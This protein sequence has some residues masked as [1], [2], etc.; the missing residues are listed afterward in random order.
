MKHP[1]QRSPRLAPFALVAILVLWLAGCGK[2]TAQVPAPAPAPT[3]VATPSGSESAASAAGTGNVVAGN[4]E[5]VSDNVPG[6]AA[7]PVAQVDG[8]STAPYIG[9]PQLVLD[10]AALTD[11]RSTIDATSDLLEAGVAILEKHKGKPE[12]AADAL[13]NYQSKHRREM[14][15]VFRRASEVRARMRSAGYDQDMPAEVRNEFEARMAK[16]QK[17]LE[18]MRDVYRDHIDALEAFGGFF[19][20][21]DA[22]A[23][24]KP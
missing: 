14:D 6:P 21:I 9:D 8:G 10:E 17:R 18:T 22:Q 1:T 23:T 7:A 2:P 11:V 20:R 4:S 12:Q 3:K 13:R 24:T 5:S 15:E 19:P 16:I